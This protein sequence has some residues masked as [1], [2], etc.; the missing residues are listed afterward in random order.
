MTPSSIVVFLA[1]HFLHVREAGA[2]SGCRVEAIQKWGGGRKGDS[3]CCW[4]ATMVLDLAFVGLSP[5]PRMGSCQ[6]VLDLAKKNGWTRPQGM[7][8]DLALF[9]NSEGRAHHIGICTQDS[10]KGDCMV[11]AGNTSKDGKSPN[12]T[13]VYEHLTTPDVYV[14]YPR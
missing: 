9:L 5:I 1:R 13:G 6:E 3:W 12:G 2:N 4:F 10:Y 14:A 8:G 11:I 7:A